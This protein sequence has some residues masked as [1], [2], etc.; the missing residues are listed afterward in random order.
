MLDLNQLYKE[1]KSTLKRKKIINLNLD[2]PPDSHTSTSHNRPSGS[3]KPS[4]GLSGRTSGRQ[5]DPLS[6]K[7]R[8]RQTHFW[9]SLPD[10][11]SHGRKT[12]VSVGCVIWVDCCSGVNGCM[13]CV[14]IRGGLCGSNYVFIYFV[15]M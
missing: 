8:F 1:G 4:H 3:G 13:V 12:D 9:N 7:I 5:I 10:P 6:K 15:V 11:T 14:E 2:T